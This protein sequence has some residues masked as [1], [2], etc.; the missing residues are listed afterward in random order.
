MVDDLNP[1]VDKLF[2]LERFLGKGGW[3]FIEISSLPKNGDNAF[4]TVKV[5]GTIDSFE[6]SDYTL[7]PRGNG[8]LLLAVK[9]EI[10]KA[11]GKEEGDSVRVVL[12][13]D[14]G[15]F[16]IPEEFR[17]ALEAEPGV[18]EKFSAYKKWEQRL[19]IKWI[20]S[21]KREETKRERIIRAIFRITRREKLV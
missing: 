11:I 8:N 3:T 13:K 21:A 12:Y 17:R 14:E 10:R 18:F 4:G 6:I 16:E 7:M 15:E 19:C 5:K 9:A 2:V 20:Y 1:L